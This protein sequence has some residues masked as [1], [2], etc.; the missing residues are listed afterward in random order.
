MA[1]S[2]KIQPNSLTSGPAKTASS[3]EEAMLTGKRGTPTASSEMEEIFWNAIQTKSVNNGGTIKKLL[4]E[5]PKLADSEREGLSS[6]NY[7]VFVGNIKAAEAILSSVSPDK[8]IELLNKQDEKGY[9]PLHWAAIS[10]NPLEEQQEQKDMITLLIK[11]GAKDQATFNEIIHEQI[12]APPS[13]LAQKIDEKDGTQIAAFIRDV[14]NANVEL[15]PMSLAKSPYNELWELL[16]QDAIARESG[17]DMSK[18]NTTQR[19]KELLNDNPKLIK[20]I[21]KDGLKPLHYAAQHNQLE[22]ASHILNLAGTKKDNIINAET[23]YE[24]ITALYI[25]AGSITSSAKM[26]RLLVDQGAANKKMNDERIPDE[27]RMT[28]DQFAIKL[29][30]IERALIINPE[31]QLS[32]KQELEIKKEQDAIEKSI[33]AS[34]PVSGVKERYRTAGKDWIRDIDADMSTFKSQYERERTENRKQSKNKKELEKKNLEAWNRLKQRTESID[35]ECFVKKNTK[36][37]GHDGRFSTREAAEKAYKKDYGVDKSKGFYMANIH[38]HFETIAKEIHKMESSHIS[39]TTSHVMSTMYEHRPAYHHFV[40]HPAYGA[41]SV[42]QEKLSSEAKQVLSFLKTL[43]SGIYDKNLNAL[44]IGKYFGKDDGIVAMRELLE[45]LHPNAT[46][47]DILQ[48]FNFVK[49]ILEKKVSENEKSFKLRSDLRKIYYASE[50]IAVQEINF[51]MQQKKYEKSF[52][53][54]MKRKLDN[55]NQYHE[56][57][58][59]NN[60]DSNKRKQQ[61]AEEVEQIKEILKDINDQSV[62][63]KT[64]IAYKKIEQILN[65]KN[66]IETDFILESRKGIRQT[67]EAGHREPATTASADG[68]K[69][70]NTY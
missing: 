14:S 1:D 65:K 36:R 55:P 11:H 48:V 53:M 6:L 37:D 70:K 25:A 60:Y 32:K 46:E 43:E 45:G 63:E 66:C 8:K 57:Y 40:E 18:S 64:S 33:P 12:A 61:A 19:I 69:Y 51:N 35:M 13:E 27:A 50:L 54:E 62:T 41:F 21:N 52:L 39:S 10:S 58:F 28:A 23:H 4:T 31:L 7:A 47:N 24:G 44:G 67:L 9:T 59:V 56:N 5:M 34:Q 38:D 68:S 42:N 49:A 3:E 30:H 15:P 26:V 2:R 20:K 16:E 22:V 17:K 29:G